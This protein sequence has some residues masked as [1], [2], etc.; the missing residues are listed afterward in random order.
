MQWHAQNAKDNP[1]IIHATERC[2]AGII[3]AIGHFKL[4]PNTSPR[5]VADL[6]S[7]KLDNFS[8]GHE[9]VV[10]YLLYERWHRAEIEKSDMP[11]QYLK[12][13]FVSILRCVPTLYYFL[14]IFSLM[15]SFD[16]KHIV[17]SCVNHS[18]EL[19]LLVFK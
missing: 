6:S 1:R 7:C 5:D 11:I 8:P 4:G 17:F 12:S 18:E 16:E 14:S 9:V 15:I 10:F 19:R 3:Q 13:I 2:A